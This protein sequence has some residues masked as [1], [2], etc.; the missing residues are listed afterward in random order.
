MTNLLT[1]AA[2][3]LRLAITHAEVVWTLESLQTAV[4]RHC[5][6]SLFTGYLRDS[7]FGTT[8]LTKAVN[9]HSKEQP[10]NRPLRLRIFSSS[11]HGTQ[12]AA[13]MHEA[14]HRE[15]RT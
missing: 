12:S 8:R 14:S 10:K 6:S 3:F 5:L 4:V 9:T 1:C 13:H 11:K 2:A 15:T 7:F